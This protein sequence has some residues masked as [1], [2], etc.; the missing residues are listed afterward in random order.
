M[1][2]DW[3][4]CYIM[5]GSAGATFIGLLFVVVTLGTGWSTP[6]GRAGV[7][8]FLN[9]TLTAASRTTHSTP[10]ATAGASS[11]AREVSAH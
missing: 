10:P 6:Q 5:A 4:D 3:A 7:D 1:L 8:A 9:P 11:A 2:R